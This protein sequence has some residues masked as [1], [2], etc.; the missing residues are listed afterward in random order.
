MRKCPA[1][2]VLK[3]DES[4]TAEKKCCNSCLKKARDYYQSHRSQA[5][6]YQRKNAQIIKLKVMQHYGGL[7]PTCVCCDESEIT[8]LEIDHINGKGSEHRKL[9]G[10]GTTFYRWLI[11]MHYP[12]GF[13][14]LCCN[15][16]KGK[17]ILGK[18]P[19]QIKRLP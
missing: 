16:N 8:F 17:A 15:C 2:H 7:Y 9:T 14:I 3:N 18:C 12:Q 6:E 10:E 11:R 1:C 5:L 13:Q 19:H 4:F